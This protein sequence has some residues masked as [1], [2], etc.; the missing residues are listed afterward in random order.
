[1]NLQ[2][3]S[4]NEEEGEMEKKEE[5]RRK[6]YLKKKDLVDLA[7]EKMDFQICQLTS[8]KPLNILHRQ[9]TTIRN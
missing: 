4:M 6:G 3:R 5:H 9:N 8:I 2:R 1:M 7:L